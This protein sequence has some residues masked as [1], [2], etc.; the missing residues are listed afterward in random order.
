[1]TLNEIVMIHQAL[2]KLEMALDASGEEIIRC[3]EGI[4]L[5]EEEVGEILE[6]LKE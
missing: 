5:S 4:L 2:D 6:S 1:V 3:F